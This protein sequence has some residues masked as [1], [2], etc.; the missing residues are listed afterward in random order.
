MQRVLLIKILDALE[1]RLCAE[2]MQKPASLD[3]CTLWLCQ[4]NIGRV[5]FRAVV[6]QNRLVS[7]YCVCIVAPKGTSYVLPAGRGSSVTARLLVLPSAAAA[8]AAAASANRRR[9]Q[10]LF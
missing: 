2:N 5:Y 10:G 1:S 8:A 6:S 3:S 9:L 4:N 7:I